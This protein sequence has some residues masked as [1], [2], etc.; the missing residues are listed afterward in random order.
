VLQLGYITNCI[1]EKPDLT[2]TLFLAEKQRDLSKDRYDHLHSSEEKVSYYEG[3]FP[4][5]RPVKENTLFILFAAALFFI[6]LALFIFLRTQGVEVNVILPSTVALPGISGI[7]GISSIPSA[8]SM[9]SFFSSFSFFISAS[10]LIGIAAGY[11]I[12]VYYQ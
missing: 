11:A 6:L 5:Y 10:I 9:S 8:S 1:T 3:T 4:I 12:Q 7:P 2:D